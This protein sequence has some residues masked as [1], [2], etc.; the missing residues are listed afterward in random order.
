MGKKP[1]FMDIDCLSLKVGDLEAAIAFYAGK[2]G[3]ELKWKT[4]TS[5]GLRFPNGGSELVL[6]TEKRPPGTDLLVES[7]SDAVRRFEEAGGN[8][9]YGPV[10]IPVGSFAIVA[11]PWGNRLTVLDL[12]KGTYR[13]DA[14]GNVIGVG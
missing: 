6:H 12:S 2:L 5:A 4:P 7:V 14:D 3:Q 9:V 11:D 10:E 1:L 8:L 13:V